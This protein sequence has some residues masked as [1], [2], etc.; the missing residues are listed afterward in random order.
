V[1]PTNVSP[2][3]AER[4]LYLLTTTRW[5]SV[6]FV[7][8]IFI[9]VQTGRGLTIAQAATIGSVMGLT[10]FFLELPTSGF[11]D[12]V[13]RRPVYLT[14]AVIN[15]VA[16]VGYALA[17][18]FW[19]F[20]VAGVL[21]GVFRALDSG[22]LE[23]WFV[24]TVHETTPGADV[25]RQLSRAGTIL[26]GA[27]A[28]GAV[29]SGLLIWWNPVVTV[30]GH[31][32][33]SPLDLAVWVSAALTVVHL[34]A[35]F[36]VMKEPRPTAGSER[37][38]VA[39][40]L[41]EARRTPTVI[42][43]GLLLLGRNRVLMGIVAAEVFWSIGMITFESFMPLRLEELVGSAQKAGAL[44]G[45][46]SAAGWGLF[47]VGAWLAGM[48]SSRYGVARAAILGRVLNAL[49]AVVMGLVTGPA[50]LIAAYLFTYSMHGMNGPP[51]AALLH[52][53]AEAK[54]RSTVLSINSMMAFLAF[55]VA[56]PLFGL[57]ADR[58]SLATAMATAG[59]ISILGAF[60]YLPARRAEKAR[61]V[62]PAEADTLAG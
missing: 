31:E 43:S 11:A 52:R 39:H 48:T 61:S 27:I 14:A 42:K 56:G 57:M 13:G 51:H 9:L 18:S 35:A 34:V 47:S 20:V 53:E 30:L 38:R 28:V 19:A 26:G 8:G 50:G 12:A 37:T 1:S 45:P 5:L 36:V 2:H 40:A 7:V 55:G 58:V 24:D 10:C 23:A 4:R 59:A 49:G 41:S 21:M 3:A 22:P 6:G 54:N 15:V 32:D 16:I 25:D 62:L 17:Q 29:L 33:A 46:V 44:V 60:F